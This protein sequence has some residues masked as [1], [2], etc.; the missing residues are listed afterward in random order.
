MPSVLFE[1]GLLNQYVAPAE[2]DSWELERA[3][4]IAGDED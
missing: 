3:I 1:Y 2:A 4:N